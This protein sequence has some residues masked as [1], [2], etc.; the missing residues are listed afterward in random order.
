MYF[1]GLENREALHS[2]FETVDRRRYTIGRSIEIAQQN[3][4]V[5][6]HRLEQQPVAPEPTQE[7]PSY[8]NFGRS[9]VEQVDSANRAESAQQDLERIYGDQETV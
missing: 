2:A 3:P 9:A 4:I 6:R 1:D 7:A 8:A 5:R